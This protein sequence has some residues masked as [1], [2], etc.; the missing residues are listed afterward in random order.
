M[1]TTYSQP[2]QDQR[3]GADV[4]PGASRTSF[5]NC[6]TIGKH[7]RGYGLVK[8]EWWVVQGSNL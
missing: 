5:G 1:V 7:Q 6:G 8:E 4:G 3:L 2:L